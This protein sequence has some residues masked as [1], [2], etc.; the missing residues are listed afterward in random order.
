MPA[1]SITSS[2]MRA[3]LS[4]DINDALLDFENHATHCRPCSN[5]VLTY[6]RRKQLCDTGLRMRTEVIRLMYLK[7]EY[8]KGGQYTLDVE[9]E[10]G[11]QAADGLIRIITHNKQGIYTNTVIDLKRARPASMEIERA[12]KRLEAAPRTPAPAPEDRGSGYRE[13]L[14]RLERTHYTTQRGHAAAEVYGNP[15]TSYGNLLHLPSSSLAA[16]SGSSNGDTHSDSRLSSGT[17]SVKFDNR[18]KVREFEADAR[19]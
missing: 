3:Q 12:P 9:L 5:P 19:V 18:V 8:T 15:N 11:W 1:K 6:E 10:Y 14:Q 7:A 13:D 4:R 2:E 17:R 16:N